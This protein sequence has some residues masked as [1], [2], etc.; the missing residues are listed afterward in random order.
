MTTLLGK[1]CIDDTDCGEGYC[2]NK[3]GLTHRCASKGRNGASCTKDTQ[4]ISNQCKDKNKNPGMHYANM[5][6]VQSYTK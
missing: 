3:F 4:C 1:K 5:K 2:S 6:C